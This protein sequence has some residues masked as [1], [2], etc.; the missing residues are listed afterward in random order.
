[1]SAYTLT[2]E[3]ARRDQSL[4]VWT[5]AVSADDGYQDR[6]TVTTGER[7]GILIDAQALGSRYVSELSRYPEGA[8]TGD[9]DLDRAFI[10]RCRE[11]VARAKLA[12]ILAQPAPH[13]HRWSA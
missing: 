12:R 8:T 11:E 1:M 5:F 4:I 13:A 6:W 2:L 3:N 7:V 10:T 9:P